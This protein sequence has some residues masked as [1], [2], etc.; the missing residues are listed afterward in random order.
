MTRAH[1][2]L[3]RCVLALAPCRF[4]TATLGLVATLLAVS[5]A[6]A[7][8]Q[9]IGGVELIELTIAEAHEAMLGGTLTSRQLVEAYLERIDAY[10]RNGPTINSIIL[11]N[12]RVM[13]RADSLDTEL[14][15][16][17]ELTGPLH[18]IPFIVKDNF[19]THDMPTTGGSAS[20]AGSMAADDAYQV[21]KIREAGAIVL[22]KSN[23]AEF[24]FTALETVGSMLPGWTFNP[25]ALN[26]VT[27][28]SSGGTAAAVA[29]NMGL[30]GLGSD[31]GNSI[32]GPSSHNALVGIRSTQGLTSR[33][34]IMP[35]FA[36]RDVGGPMGRTVEDVV[37]VFDVIAGTD[38]A[39]AV[40][41]E[42]DDRRAESYL[43][44][45]TT[46][47]TGVRI[48][49]A[50][51]IAYKQSA[52]VE[53]LMRFG[54]AIRDL[55]RLGATVVR[56]FEIDDLAALR[57]GTGCSSFRYDIENYL[58]AIPDPPVHTL[59]EIAESGQVYRTVLPTVRRFLDFEGTPETNERC[60]QGREGEDRFRAGVRAAMAKYDVQAIIYPSW[61]NPPRLVGDMT[62]PAGDN[63]QWPA[64]PTG[65]PALTVPMGFVREQTLPAGLQVLGDAWSEPLLIQIAY[66]YEQATTHRKPPPTAPPL[67][68]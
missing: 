56:D 58:A 17:G 5:T 67:N 26:R 47:L 50:K 24:A 13:A 65:F 43:D 25:Y 14:R 9:M 16:T 18:G 61:S 21:R 11:L 8:A 1:R 64:P 60:I 46:D 37:R 41:V 6:P 35:L 4:S 27:A 34:G 45:L 68:R 33:D 62:T 32:R 10:D 20:L 53:I 36:H 51:Q 44:F 29:A 7:H 2:A 23:L 38:P 54:E 22:A 59:Q 15:R 57:R 31:T 19:D 3:D 66:A 52:D 49:V 48:G 40:T 55:E 63:S 28:G 39:D 12:P 42:A 30:I